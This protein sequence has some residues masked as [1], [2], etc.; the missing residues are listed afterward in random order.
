MFQ[1]H[2]SPRWMKPH[3]ATPPTPAFDWQPRGDG[4][5]ASLSSKSSSSIQQTH[6][7]RYFSVFYLNGVKHLHK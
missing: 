5:T 1:C 4:E 2:S 6:K 3:K 7:Q